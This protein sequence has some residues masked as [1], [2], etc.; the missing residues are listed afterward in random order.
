[1]RVRCNKDILWYLIL[2]GVFAVIIGVDR[3]NLIRI[4][5]T[6]SVSRGV[7][8]RIPQKK[9]SHGC[10]VIFELPDS[11]SSQLSTASWYPDSQKFIK[12]VVGVEGDAVESFHN[13]YA[14][15]GVELFPQFPY[16]R[17]GNPLPREMDDLLVV[18]E[19]MV[20]VG[21]PHPYSFDS[22]YFGPL[23]IAE[24]DGVYQLLW[25]W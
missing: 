6:A 4:N 15:S 14:V 2:V 24:I 25:E 1:M 7:Y 11:L 21:S 16:D 18:P 19:G 12:E 5:L 23:D 9:I 17:E 8:I 13:G 20:L 3:C 22:R 10:Y